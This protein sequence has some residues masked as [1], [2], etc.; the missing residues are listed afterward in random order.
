MTRRWVT[1]HG[2][3]RLAVHDLGPADAPAIMFV[4]GWSQAALAWARQHPL[5]GRFRLVIPDLRGHGQSDKPGEEAAYLA[6]R[7]WAEDLAAV[8]A[9]RGLARPVLVGWSMGGWVVGDY[10]R[11][12]G[13]E[14]LAGFALVGSS[15]T[16]GEKLPPKALAAR[17]ADADVSAKAMFGDDLAEN[18]AA[19]VRFVR[20]CFHRQPEPDDL[21][22][23]VGYNMLCPP[24]A[25]V[26]RRRSED[27]RAD[28]ARTTRPALLLR[29]RH[30]R[31]SLPPMLEEA[32]ATLPRARV[33]EY[34]HSGHSPF[35]EEADR[36]NAD[37]ARF[38]E[39]A[40]S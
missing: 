3:V 8:I 6:S 18:L 24:V 22:T 26:S 36:F 10:L 34:D 12:F 38:V 17:G 35:W 37:L 29:G 19:T 40:R 2:G 7:P 25:R 30:E 9:A 15:V 5:A 1:G 33:L 20:A 4:H 11:H 23:I 28:Y 39:E 32:R 16:C 14:A 13:D 31:M 21:A 27:W